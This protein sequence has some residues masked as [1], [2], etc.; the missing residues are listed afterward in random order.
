FEQTAVALVNAI[1]TKDKY[2]H[3]HSS[4]VAEYSRRLAEMNHMSEDEC[5][6][7]YYTA[8]LHDVGKIG[9]PNSI[10]N[11][12][13]KLTDEEYDVIKQHPGN[14]AKILEKI[15]EYPLLSTGARYH[16][17]RYDGKGYPK[18]LKG[19][20]I[21][22]IARIIA[23]AD[24][25]DAMTSIRSYRDPIP[26]DKVREEIVKGIGT[27][28]DPVYARL[29]LHLIDVDTEYEMQEQTKAKESE[30]GE[31]TV[32]EHRSAVGDGII[33]AP[34]KRTISVS[35]NSCDEATGIA[36]AP[37]MILYDSLDGKVHTDERSINDRLYFEYGEIWFD[38][39]TVT[40]GARKMQTRIIDSGSAEIRHKGDY[41]I[42]AVRIEDHA[43]IRIEGRDQTAEVIVALPDSTR[44]LYIALTGENCSMYGM[45]VVR[46][47]TR[48][49]D[50]YIP[51]IAEKISFIDTPAGDI[52]NVQIDGFRTASSEGIEIRDGL[53]LTFHTRSLPT[54]RLIWHCPFIDIF[55]S[56]DGK[57]DGEN[58]RDLGFVRFDGECGGYDP[59]CSVELK[60][61]KTDR[62]EDWDSWKKYNQDGYDAVVTFKVNNDQIT[63]ITENAGISISNT[64][65]M[66]GID[67]TIYAAI[68]GDQ[69]AVTNIRMQ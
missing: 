69:V 14:G 33:I 22:E 39:H 41:R 63:V 9:V 55:C 4:R 21:P 12:A 11:K 1:D 29:M 7:V 38:G 52:P 40:G 45:N 23:V 27:Q 42:E 59:D 60:V 49:P 15:S 31:F 62:F 54:S 43:L 51:R 66:N 28:F 8:L 67:K 61:K 19:E 64:F 20:D 6:M 26:Q 35:V 36:P 68:T 56:D 46:S 3:G 5:N 34:N 32:G 50:D 30:N 16:H 24:A 58:Y 57:A 10:I 65:I 13:G 48:S 17:E 25:Y 37:S 18:G 53:K 2:T 47:E 44:F